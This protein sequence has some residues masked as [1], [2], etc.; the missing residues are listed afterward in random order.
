LYN[1]SISITPLPFAFRITTIVPK[2][3]LAR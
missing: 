1:D 3:P 2:P